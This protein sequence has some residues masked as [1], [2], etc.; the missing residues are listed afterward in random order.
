MASIQD[1]NEAPLR[2]HTKETNKMLWGE[3][4]LA[5]HTSSFKVLHAG[6]HDVQT[7]WGCTSHLFAPFSV[8]DATNQG[9]E[10]SAWPR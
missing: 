4:K 5:I 9:H 10:R 8:M 3:A 1:R 6:S 2:L 7:D